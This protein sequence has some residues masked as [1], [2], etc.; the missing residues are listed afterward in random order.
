MNKGLKESQDTIPEDI[1]KNMD[2]ATLSKLFTMH[3]K[4]KYT[5][6]VNIRYRMQIYK[7][8]DAQIS[9]TELYENYS[10]MNLEQMINNMYTGYYINRITVKNI[11]IH[12]NKFV[13]D[14]NVFIE[15]SN[16]EEKENEENG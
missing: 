1:F 7:S 9:S 8:G 11:Y 6:L 2:N 10:V 4:M 3:K 14:I 16:I 13:L 5:D 12:N 15:K